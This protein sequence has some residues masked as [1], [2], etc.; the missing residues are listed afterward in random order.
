[1]ATTQV[2]QLPPPYKGQQDL[3]PLTAAEWPYAQFVQNFNLDTGIAK[4][5]K[6]DTAFAT[7]ATTEQANS[8]S[9][10]GY[11]STEQM[12]CTA[13]RSSGPTTYFYNVSAGTFPAAVHSVAGADPGQILTL[14]FNN[15]LMFFGSGGSLLP[16][17]VGPQYWNGAAWG[18]LAYVWPTGFTVP[19]GA[20]VYKNRAYF[21][22]RGTQ[23]YGYS[24]VDSIAG[25]VT[26]V[27]LSY[28]APTTSALLNIVSVA[29]SEGIQQQ[30]VLAFIFAD[31]TILCYAGSW[32]NSTDWELIAWFK[33]PPVLQ[34]FNAICR[35]EGDVWVLTRTSI[36]SLRSLFTQGQSVAL[37]EPI[38]A[39]ISNRWTEIIK[40]VE[41][42]YTYAVQDIVAVWDTE[43]D[44]VTITFPQFAEVGALGGALRNTAHRLCYSLTTR[45]WWE[46]VGALNDSFPK[47]QTNPCY[48]KQN[49]YYLDYTSTLPRVFLAEDETAAVWRDSW[50]GGTDQPYRGLLRSVPIPSRRN[51]LMKYQGIE[52][53]GLCAEGADAQ[54]KTYMELSTTASGTQPLSTTQT[55]YQ[56]PFINIGGTAGYIQYQFDVTTDSAT[57]A[58]GVELHG[59][60]AWIEEGGYR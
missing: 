32:P 13:F 53:I 19:M 4:L 31:G 60:N 21:I 55:G 57:N 25:T 22:N 40:K 6:P 1:M 30:S 58:Q 46:Q 38:T 7:S 15:Y 24:P 49:L 56:K 16:A 35:V 28:V 5:R 23:T 51:A 29:L 8:L 39:A 2:L 11:G 47:R 14:M 54:V 17:S 20:E 18:T 26:A 45:A 36:V 34:S 33:I 9:T 43:R 50:R 44:R 52:T 59:I 10:Y 3:I 41:T 12:F 37:R 27:N 48:Y 42:A